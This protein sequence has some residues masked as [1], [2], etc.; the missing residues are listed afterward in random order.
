[1]SSKS[2]SKDSNRWSLASWLTLWYSALAATLIAGTTGYSYWVLTSNL[3]HEDDEFLLKYLQDVQTRLLNDPDEI[4]ELRNAWSHLPNEPSPIHIVM[5]LLK[6]DGSI[7]LEMPGSE[8]IPWPPTAF[9][10]MTEAIGSP[11]GWLC[12]SQAGALPSGDAIVMQAAIDRRPES[13]ILARY[14]QQLYVVFFVAVIAGAIGGVLIARWG[15]RPLQKLSAVA[16]GIEANQMQQRLDSANYAAELQQVALTFNGMLDRLQESF[17]RLN[18]FSGDIAHELRTPLHILRGEVEVALNKCRSEEEY[19]DV[20]GSCLEETVRLSRLVDSLLF[21]ARSEQPQSAL[22]REPLCLADELKTIQDF[23][24]AAAD[25]AGV[26]LSVT[27][28]NP[29]FMA[30]R[31]LFQRAIGNLITNAI[32]HTPPDGHIEILGTTIQTGIRVTVIDTGSGIGPEHLPYVFDRLYRGSGARSGAPGYGL[33]L[34]IVKTIVELH[35]G[36]IEIQS[37]EGQGTT[38]DILWPM[39]IPTCECTSSGSSKA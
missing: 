5:R 13:V 30:D 12:R 16:A 20:L 2:V 9:R 33:G 26:S 15:L 35:G 8:D 7:M 36:Q 17:E 32:A 3:N 14:R 34:C 31:T 23:Y 1:M 29:E 27:T 6:A 28:S 38:V 22:K 24:D 39:M 19:R 21:L 18:R 25:D 10:G 37:V 11:G 4:A